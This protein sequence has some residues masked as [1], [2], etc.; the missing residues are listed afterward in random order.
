MISGKATNNTEIMT[1]IAIKQPRCADD[2]VPTP[3]YR[4]GLGFDYSSTPS[5]V[6]IVRPLTKDRAN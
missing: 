6:Y 1:A 2:Y 3:T 5:Y 4:R